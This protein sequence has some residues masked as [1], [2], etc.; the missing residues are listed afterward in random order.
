LILGWLTPLLK[1]YL[2]QIF[3]GA[4]MP[5]RV[6][7]NQKLIVKTFR[8][9]GASVQV[10][11]NIGKGCPDILVGIFGKNF[12]VEIKNGAKCPS[13]QKLTEHEQ[14]FFDSWKGQVCIIKSV[15]EIFQLMD[16]IVKR[17]I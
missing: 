7:E 12:L 2:G 5:K 13:A 10:L 1:F 8:E 3:K 14:V 4:W 16:K 11:S 17:E 9:L 6:D 15:D